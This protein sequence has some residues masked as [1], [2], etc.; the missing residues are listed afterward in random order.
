MCVR[1]LTDDSAHLL[2]FPHN[3]NELLDSPY[4]MVILTVSLNVKKDKE[5]YLSACKHIINQ[6][7]AQLGATMSDCIAI[8]RLQEW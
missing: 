7:M 3:N 8:M 1:M 6:K 2:W 5:H 4:L